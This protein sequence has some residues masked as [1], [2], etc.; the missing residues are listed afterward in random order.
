MNTEFLQQEI[1]KTDESIKNFGIEFRSDVIKSEPN[2][3]TRGSSKVR[4]KW[5]LETLIYEYDFDNHKYCTNGF[6]L[7]IS[8][9]NRAKL[10]GIGR[11]LPFAQLVYISTT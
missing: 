10:P 8:S 3:S 9:L 1:T 6:F 4:M 2:Y 5:W 11:L 7:S